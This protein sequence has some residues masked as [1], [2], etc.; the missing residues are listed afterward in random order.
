NRLPRILERLGHLDERSERP[1]DV[2]VQLER[3]LAERAADDLAGKPAAAAQGNLIDGDARREFAGE[4]PIEAD[5][6]RA[7]FEIAKQLEDGA[8][9]HPGLR[10]GAGIFELSAGRPRIE[11]AADDPAAVL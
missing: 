10:L 4:F 11:P 9:H 2:E 7:I 8:G 5:D 3:Y 6:H 1:V